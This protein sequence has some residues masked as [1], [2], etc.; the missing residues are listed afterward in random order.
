MYF[1][2]PLGILNDE[3]SRE[4]NQSTTITDNENGTVIDQEMQYDA[5]GR[6]LDD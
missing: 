4:E 5:W 1:R 6:L 3:D 2:C